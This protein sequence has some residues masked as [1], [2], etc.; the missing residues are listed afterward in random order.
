MR[1]N[2][3]RISNLFWQ[4]PHPRPPPS[5]I[6]GA[7]FR[8][9]GIP[10][11]LTC[12]ALEAAISGAFSTEQIRVDTSKTRICSSCCDQRTRT[13]LIG[14]TPHA[15]RALD[16]LPSAGTYEVEI[17]DLH[18]DISIDRDF[19]GLTQLYSTSGT[20]RAE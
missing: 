12:E 8:V 17:P 16:T 4:Q 18:C 9:T 2:L 3:K 11:A 13:A 15:P 7:I 10:R 19:Q 20:I 5:T 14:F 6:K 1:R